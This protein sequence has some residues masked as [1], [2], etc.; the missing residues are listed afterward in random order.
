MSRSRRRS[1][2]GEHNN[3]PWVSKENAALAFYKIIITTYYARY[4]HLPRIQLLKIQ[5][6]THTL[7]HRRAEIQLQ[8]TARD[9]DTK[10]IGHTAFSQDAATMCCLL[11]APLSGLSDEADRDRVRERERERQAERSL[12]NVIISGRDYAA[13]CA[14]MRRTLECECL[15]SRGM[16]ERFQTQHV[17]LF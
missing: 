7:T 15:A 8:A 3:S 14:P 6:Y 10:L 17:A 1:R 4:A 9:T 2:R 12:K 5:R 11:P 13:I 16:G